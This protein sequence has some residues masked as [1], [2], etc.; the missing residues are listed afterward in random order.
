MTARFLHKVR[1]LA[2]TLLKV[3]INTIDKLVNVKEYSTVRKRVLWTRHVPEVEPIAFKV[4]LLEADL[5]REF[6]HQLG[7]KLR[8]TD[9]K[10]HYI[11]ASVADAIIF[12]FVYDQGAHALDNLAHL[13]VHPANELLPHLLKLADIDIFTFY[14]L[15]FLAD[16]LPHISDSL[17]QVRNPV[18]HFKLIILFRMN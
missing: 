13:P 15:L 4:L 7:L 3:L 10:I 8:I 18:N 14:R 16:S 9:I 11:G 6:E 12:N 1:I 17:L 5:V 2:Q